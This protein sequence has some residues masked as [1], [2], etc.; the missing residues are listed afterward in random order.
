[1][2]WTSKLQ[3]TMQLSHFEK[4]KCNTVHGIAQQHS[5]AEQIRASAPANINIINIKIYTYMSKEYLPAI[6][7]RH[8]VRNI[9]HIES[10]S[11]TS[12]SHSNVVQQL[13]M[14]DS[15]ALTQA[16]KYSRLHW[17]NRLRCTQ[18]LKPKVTDEYHNFWMQQLQKNQSY[19]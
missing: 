15:H 8:Q 3:K 18:Q 16:L 13:Y 1:M 6:C 10:A 4:K 5:N 11:V 12:L 7:L 2:Y 17:T 19:W 14:H 9:S